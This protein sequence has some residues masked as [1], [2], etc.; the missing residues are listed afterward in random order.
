[1]TRFDESWKAARRY[2][3]TTNTRAMYSP[4]TDP[5]LLFEAAVMRAAPSTSRVMLRGSSRSVVSV[6]HTDFP[7]HQSPQ[8]AAASLQ[9]ACEPPLSVYFTSPCRGR[10]TRLFSLVARLTG[11]ALPE[12][13]SCTTGTQNSWRLRAT[14]G[15]DTLGDRIAMLTFPHHSSTRSGPRRVP[16]SDRL[17]A[18]RAGHLCTP[19]SLQFGFGR[20]EQAPKDRAES[21]LLLSVPVDETCTN[22]TTNSKSATTGARSR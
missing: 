12:A 19:T 17:S 8:P 10:I 6:P 13:S 20:H 18:R 7:S 3:P 4:C 5:K 11:L 9:S 16:Q 22:S 1:M 14:G 15:I 2:L 21:S